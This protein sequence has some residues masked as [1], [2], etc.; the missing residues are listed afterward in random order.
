MDAADFAGRQASSLASGLKAVGPRLLQIA[1]GGGV[2]PLDRGDLRELEQR[3]GTREVLRSAVVRRDAEVLERP[4]RREHRRAVGEVDASKRR[5]DRD[6]ANRTERSLEEGA[7]GEL[8]I[9]NLGE[10]RLL[11]GGDVRR[12]ECRDEAR[13]KLRLDL[14]EHGREL[15]D[16]DV[17]LREVDHDRIAGCGNTVARFGDWNRSRRRRRQAGARSYPRVPARA[18]TPA[19]K[20]RSRGSASLPRVRGELASRVVSSVMRSPVA[21]GGAEITRTPR[22]KGIEWT[23]RVD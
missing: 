10:H 8:V 16:G 4:G 14:L 23:G 17:A 9:A 19:A 22:A 7:V 11:A 2:A 13:V 15:H 3:R 18:G 6:G 5:G 12:R 21:G 20:S 1:D